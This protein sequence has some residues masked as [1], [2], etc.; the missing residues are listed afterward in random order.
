M[1]A[2]LSKKIY[3]YAISFSNQEKAL[4]IYWKI[5]QHLSGKPL[6]GRS[7]SITTEYFFSSAEWE[8]SLY[9]VKL[10][11]DFTDDLLQ[12]LPAF[13]PVISDSALEIFQIIFGQILIFA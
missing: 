1:S 8:L 13:D 9:I 5:F 11:M 12:I 3:T 6:N 2:M 4:I 7:I 10:L